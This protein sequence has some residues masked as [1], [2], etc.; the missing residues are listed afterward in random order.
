MIIIM[1]LQN[2]LKKYI[3]KSNFSNFH[4]FLEK[5]SLKTGLHDKRNA[6]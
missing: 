3:L 6:L 5:Y 4:F 2:K 1:F